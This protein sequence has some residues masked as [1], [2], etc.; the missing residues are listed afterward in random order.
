MLKRSFSSR[1]KKTQ[2]LLWHFPFLK[3]SRR[4]LAKIEDYVPL[5][6]YDK[7]IPKEYL[8]RISPD[9]LDEER[10]LK[11]LRGQRDAPI[12]RKNE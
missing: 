4:E 11:F 9:M 5:S 7:V 10:I 1:I 8:S 3:E 12:P 6:Q 2:C